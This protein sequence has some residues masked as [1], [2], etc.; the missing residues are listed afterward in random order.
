MVTQNQLC[1]LCGVCRPR[2]EGLRYRDSGEPLGRFYGQWDGKCASVGG[3][4]KVS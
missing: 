2:V 1:G 3:L 4:Y